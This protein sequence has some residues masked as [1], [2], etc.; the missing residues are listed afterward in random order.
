MVSSNDVQAAFETYTNILGKLVEF[1]QNAP[2]EFKRMYDVFG[3]GVYRWEIRDDNVHVF[4]RRGYYA[5]NEDYE[6]SFPLKLVGMS[7][8]D[9]VFFVRVEQARR[10]AEQLEDNKGRE[11]AD[12]ARRLEDYQRLKKEFS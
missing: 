5:A 9:I 3:A 2:D 12:K 4:E 8:N 10:L 1:V 6:W 11:E 7:P